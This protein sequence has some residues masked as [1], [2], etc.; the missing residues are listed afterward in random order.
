MNYRPLL[1]PALPAP[2]FSSLVFPSRP[3][4]LH[5]SSLVRFSFH[6]RL[7]CLGLCLPALC[8]FPALL[9]SATPSCSY[10]CGHSLSTSCIPWERAL[11]HLSGSHHPFLATVLPGH[12]GV[13]PSISR[14][15]QEPHPLTWN[16]L[17]GGVTSAAPSATSLFQFRWLRLDS[18]P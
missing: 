7:C 12:G 3:L 18:W 9:K 8:P 5:A 15:P 1:P 6:F 2:L 16:N 13:S 14:S 10:S 4:S 17:E 11:C